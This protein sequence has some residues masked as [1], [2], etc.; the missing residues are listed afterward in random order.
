MTALSDRLSPNHREL[1]EGLNMRSCKVRALRAL[2]TTLNHGLPISGV[3]SQVRT[4]DGALQ[5][6]QLPRDLRAMPLFASIVGSRGTCS[7]CVRA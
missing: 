7:G 3:H 1:V 5:W 4:L 6:S 2:I